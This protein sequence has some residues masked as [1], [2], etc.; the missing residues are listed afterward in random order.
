MAAEVNSINW[1]WAQIGY[2]IERQGPTG[3]IRTI[4]DQAG[5]I[6]MHWAGDKAEQEWLVSHGIIS[7]E[8]A[9]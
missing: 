7:L 6:V 9:D 8:A 2:T 3:G 1:G 4:R 5:N